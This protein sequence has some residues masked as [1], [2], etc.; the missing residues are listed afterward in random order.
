MTS[1]LTQIK[2]VWGRLKM[3]QRASIVAAAAGTLS[4]IGALVYFGSQPEYGVLFSDL[5][6]ADAQSIVEKLKTANISYRLSNNGMVISVPADRVTDLRLQMASEGLISGGHVGFD[7][8]DRSSFGATDFAQRVNY[9]RALEGELARTL[10]GMD[11]VQNA[12]VH[13]TPSRDSVFTE[14]AQPAKASV[15]VRIRQN[16]ELSRERTEAVVNLIASSV[17]GLDLRDVSVMDTYGRVL[18]AP[19]RNEAGANGANSFNVHL[20]ARQ[21]LESTTAAR[22][23]TMLEPITGAGRVRA[24]VAVDLDFSQVEETEEKY[25]PKSSVIRQQQTMQ[26]SKLGAAALGA[27][28]GARA[29]D[30]SV[31]PASA[32]SPNA[33]GQ[34]ALAGAPPPLPADTRSATTTNFEIDKTVKHT[35]IGGG[36][37][38][39]LSVSVAVDHQTVNGA[40]T[41]RTPEELQKIQ[42]LVAAAVGV[43]ASRGDQ[44]VV[45]NISFG[46]FGTE[47][48]PSSFL[49]RY[50]DFVSLGI[51]YGSI[52]LATAL[53]LMFVV[54]PAKK[55]LM[56]AK[57][58]EQMLLTAA[59]ADG[60]T[61][62]VGQAISAESGA[63]AL[64]P[65]SASS[66]EMSLKEVVS[67]DAPLTVAELEAEIA[68]E[69]ESSVPEVKRT[70]AIKNQLVD[71]G[72]R[73]PETL[74][75]VIRGWLQ[76]SQ[77]NP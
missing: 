43:D 68:R 33:Q 18:S 32:A 10:E 75:M 41:P 38:K 30:P 57:A 42:D 47:A 16:R 31:R 66:G 60:A 4:L 59:A 67:P 23:V 14:K 61:M 49:E 7:I 44:I 12:R 36:R 45:Q 27:V 15:V 64:P 51:K 73:D 39:R 24:D 5:N 8:F 52:L 34:T 69:M 50:R 48:G 6:P 35:V 70:L 20:G 71:Q 2:E 26:E 40:L 53:I 74:A 56:A 58:P 22:I 21:A 9:Q 28:A 11:E 77:P 13:I 3:A 76:E 29:N 54:R 63:A 62:T 19:P 37:V 65:P 1:P 55:A 72:T 46:Q 17:E 25:D